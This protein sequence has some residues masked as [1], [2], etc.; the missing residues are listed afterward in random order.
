MEI[1]FILREPGNHHEIARCVSDAV[2]RS[3]EYVVLGGEHG[4]S[5]EVHSVAYVAEDGVMRADILLK[6]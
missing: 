2:P 3:G 6:E 1:R 5:R 4:V